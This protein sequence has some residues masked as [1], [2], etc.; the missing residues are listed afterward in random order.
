MA[1]SR[2]GD[3][4][5]RC[6]GDKVSGAVFAQKARMTL[7]QISRKTWLKNPRLSADLAI[8]LNCRLA[9]VVFAQIR[10]VHV[11]FTQSRPEPPA[12]RSPAPASE[13]LGP[14]PAV[15]A[16]APPGA[17]VMNAGTAIRGTGTGKSGA[18]AAARRP[19]PPSSPAA[20]PLPAPAPPFPLPPAH[21]HK[22]QAP[23]A[24]A[25]AVTMWFLTQLFYFR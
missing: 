18:A 19:A 1:V 11:R 14:A 10:I 25:A 2:S 17:A 5:F 22:T 3:P 4:R 23:A 21:L 9:G 8:S 24:P 20:P 16:P 13:S 15:S 6:V 7:I 12:P